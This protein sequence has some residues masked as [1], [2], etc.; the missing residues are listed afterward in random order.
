METM[1]DLVKDFVFYLFAFAFLLG[2]L[3]HLATGSVRALKYCLGGLTALFSVGAIAGLVLS[4]GMLIILLFQLI[5]VVLILFFTIIAGALCGGG[6]RMLL[7]GKRASKGLSKPA[8][9]DYITV[10][11]FCRLKGLEEARVLARIQSGFY[12]GGHLEGSWYVHKAELA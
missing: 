10:A 11:E 9:G 1:M 4:G 12:Q 6:I 3:L 8:I 5:I 2:L 7:D